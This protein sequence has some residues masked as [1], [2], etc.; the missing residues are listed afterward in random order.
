MTAF[1]L[2]LHMVKRVAP[3]ILMTLPF[4][5]INF[6]PF[7]TQYHPFLSSQ[8]PL[9]QV[10][11]PFS[12]PLLRR[13][14]LFLSVNLPSHQVAEEAHPLP[15]RPNKSVCPFN[16]EESTG[17]QTDLLQFFGDLNKDHAAHLLHMCS[18]PRSSLYSLF[19]WWFSFCE[20]PRVQVSWFCWS[21]C[22][23]PV[24]F[25]PLNLS[26]NSWIPRALNTQSSI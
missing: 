5:F 21:S 7:T 23:V 8:Y 9:S 13:G 4:F 10:L 14:S 2:R 18:G 11:T 15:L 20:P 16:D 24:F 3:R 19:G 12:L 6:I 25:G 22:G 1:L 17:R 26:L